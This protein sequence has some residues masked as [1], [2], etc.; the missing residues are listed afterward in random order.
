MR[1]LLDIFTS[2]PTWLKVFCVAMIALT[3]LK[4]F[5]KKDNE[6]KIRIRYR[7]VISLISIFTCLTGAYYLNDTL[8]SPASP[9][10]NHLFFFRQGVEQRFRYCCEFNIRNDGQTPC[11]L[12]KV[13]FVLEGYEFKNAKSGRVKISSG[14]RSGAMY[15]KIFSGGGG[16]VTSD[17]GSSY[18]PQSLSVMPQGFCI[19]GEAVNPEGSNEVSIAKEEKNITIRFY[20][21][22]KNKIFTEER[23][24]PLIYGQVNTVRF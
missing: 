18:F 8:P 11:N 21:K 14:G 3:V 9:Q 17:V 15:G 1:Y 13:E 7:I 20:F 5:I 16:A 10:I 24:V 23:T 22:S 2:M 4:C 12:E 19:M 6:E